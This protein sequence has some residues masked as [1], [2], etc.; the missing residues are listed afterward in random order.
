[1][2]CIATSNILIVGVQGL[3]L[4]LV[5]ILSTTASVWS[6]WY[7][8][9][10]AYAFVHSEDAGVKSITIYD[11]IPTQLHDLSPQVCPQNYIHA[12]LIAM[13]LSHR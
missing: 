11:P 9:D 4:R 1:M 13:Y 5:R 8:R 2:K 10:G 7:T 6:M 3:A 12:K